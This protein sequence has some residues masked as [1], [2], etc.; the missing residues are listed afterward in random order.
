MPILSFETQGNLEL[1]DDGE[2]K[3]AK[4]R[5]VFADD[6]QLDL[7]SAYISHGLHPRRPLDRFSYTSRGEDQI[8]LTLGWETMTDSHA[9]ALMVDQLWLWILHDGTVV[10]CFPDTCDEEAEYNLKAA[11]REEVT[12][13]AQFETV[14]DLVGCIINLSVDFFARPGPQ[15]A[16][17]IRCFQRA[18]NVVAHAETKLFTNF[19]NSASKIN[20]E[21]MPDSERRN[22]IKNLLEFHEESSLLMQIR[23][24]QDELNIVKSI[25]EQQKLVLEQLSRAIRPDLRKRVYFGNVEGIQAKVQP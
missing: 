8:M 4:S 13:T 1:F 10:T 2:T 15:A 23:D 9:P 3:V 25:V 17:F 16:T 19:K 20:Q 24:I 11:L 12:E 22:L 14:E 7:A 6:P 21:A 5:T 18:I